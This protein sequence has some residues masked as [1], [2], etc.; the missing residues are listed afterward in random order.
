MS[1]SSSF[2][3]LLLKSARLF[4]DQ[5]NAYLQT[6]HLNYSLWQVLDVLDREQHCSLVDIAQHLN[7]SAAAISCRILALD[8]KQLLQFLPSHNRREKIVGLSPAGQA[9][10]QHCQHD[11]QCLSDAL[12]ADIAPLQLQQATQVLQQL[13]NIQ[14]EDIQHDPH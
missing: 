8:Q 12:L 10:Y 2:R 7:I 11:L 1:H 14:Y 13:L 3:C 4:S 5:M 9:L 6:Q